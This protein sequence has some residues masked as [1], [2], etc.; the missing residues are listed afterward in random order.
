MIEVFGENG[1]LSSLNGRFEPREE[2]TRMA[3]F[4][5]EALCDGEGCFV[6]AGT[7]VGKTLAYLVPAIS[8]CL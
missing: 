1:I 6:E 8:H 7:G 2:Q 3:D 4:I 5:L